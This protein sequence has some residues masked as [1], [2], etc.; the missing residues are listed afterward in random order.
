MSLEAAIFDI[1]RFAVEDGPGIRS[2]VFFKGC[3][4]SCSWCQNPESQVRDAQVMYFR[5]N[6]IACGRCVEVCPKDAVRNDPDFG[7]VTDHTLCDMCGRCI[8]AC[9]TKARQ[10]VGRRMTVEAVV[11][12]LLQDEAYFR[13]SGGGVTFSGGEPLL[14][15]EAL[16]HLARRCRELGIHTALETAGSVPW[17]VFERVLPLIDLLYFDFKHIDS[18]EHLRF[19]GAPNEG[20]LDNLVRASRQPV[21]LVVRIPVV[22]G[23]NAD[24]STLRS[25]FRFL[26]EHSAARDV[27]LLPFHR[28][29]LGKYEGLGMD[30]AMK[31]TPNMDRQACEEFAR[32]GRGMGL[33]VRIGADGT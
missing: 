21:R 15:A 1:E 26:V 8:D 4:L 6:C 20:I 13:E 30:Y 32:I 12:E 10:A 31:D 14:Q 9:F 7:F 19:V 22:P 25:M 11:E 23:V 17:T 16:L 2:V 5:K 33:S 28:L 24:A 3:N 29:G 27:E 18:A